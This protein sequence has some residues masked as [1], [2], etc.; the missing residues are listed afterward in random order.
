MNS[1]PE[2]RVVA[3]IR[4]PGSYWIVDEYGEGPDAAFD[5]YHEALFEAARITKEALDN[6]DGPPDGEAWS[7]GFAENY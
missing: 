2:Y 3:A 4:F 6:Y 7:G 1:I 5:S